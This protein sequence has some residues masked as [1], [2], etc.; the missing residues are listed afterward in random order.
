MPTESREPA[1]DCADGAL[2]R[3]GQPHQLL[4]GAVH[5][6][7]VHPDLWEDRLRRLIAG[8]FN[9]VDTYVAWNFHQPEE[10]APDFTGWRDVV[11]FVEIAGDLGLDVI[12]R[13]GPYI[14]AEWSNG[15]L[16]WWVTARTHAPRTSDPAYQET[17]GRWFD[18]LIPRLAPLQ[19]A[20]GG[21]IVAVQ[22]ENEYGSYG[23]DRAHLRWLY[24]GLRRRGI[25]EL[26]FTADGNTERM[27]QAGSLD[28]VFATATLGNRAKSARALLG[29]RQPGA[30]F[31]VAEYW[32]GWFDHWG[33]SHHVRG[34]TSA[35]DAL[36]EILEN[37]GSASVYMAHG[38]TNFEL[39]AGSNHD[40]RTIQPTVTSY[41]S[42]A[43]IGEDGALTP[44]YF[45]YRDLLA[46]A[47]GRALPEPP[48]ERPRQAFVAAPL[49]AGD[50]P[51]DALSTAPATAA[52]PMPLTFE[53]LSLG[54]GIV[55]YESEV[56]LP[57]DDVELSLS[58]LRDRAHVYLDRRL[59][60]VLER[61]DVT[62]PTLMLPGGRRTAALTVVV[63][64]FGRINYGPRL[65]ERKGLVGGV[66]L[67][68]RFVHGWTH[69]I[70]PIRDLPERADLAS[71]DVPLDEPADGWIAVTGH[72]HCLVWLNG[73]LLGRLRSCGPQRRLYAPSPLWRAGANRVSVLDLDGRPSAVEVHPDADLGPIEEYVEE[74]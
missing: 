41:D 43:P 24:D 19:A 1:L 42:D 59:V 65:G 28:G 50:D 56:D 66:L 71:A 58:D 8:G 32:N 67:G 57:R 18:D 29:E 15:G 14:C 69:R 2:R 37:R 27:L 49:N 21:P 30:P 39:W 11:R 26:L 40:G 34:V 74:L 36:D 53:E 22:V 10:Q 46:R 45:A 61:D 68:G 31:V 62:A 25:V 5:Y 72:R 70:E 64:S 16:P 13:P 73:F 55:V 38:G 4:A 12:L 9:T 51:L 47:T 33:E 3:H 52:H 54:E 6:F 23:D 35:C 7:R 44:K 63:E 20:H 17:V 48:P 60:G